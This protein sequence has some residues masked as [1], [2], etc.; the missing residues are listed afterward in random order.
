MV[1]L[2]YEAI[3][4]RSNYLHIEINVSEKYRI[5]IYNLYTLLKMYYDASL[6]VQYC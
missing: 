5:C 4:K 6:N 2:F 3:T 1:H